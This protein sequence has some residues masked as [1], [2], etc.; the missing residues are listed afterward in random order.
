MKDLPK[1]ISDCV[2]VIKNDHS[3]KKLLLYKY[4]WSIQYFLDSI[5]K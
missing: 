1:P 5:Q 3:N 2:I 4:S